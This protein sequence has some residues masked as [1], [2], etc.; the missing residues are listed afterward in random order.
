MIRGI[1]KYAR[2][3][4]AFPRDT[5]TATRVTA[6]KAFLKKQ[7]EEILRRHRGGESGLAVAIARATEIDALIEHLYTYAA[8]A[9]PGG[10]PGVPPAPVAIIALGGYGRAEL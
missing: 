4:L 2:K 5:P 7:D 6:C 1:L 8:E 10:H 9:W 3:H